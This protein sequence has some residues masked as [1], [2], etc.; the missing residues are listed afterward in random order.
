[1]LRTTLLRHTLLSHLAMKGAPL[2]TIQELAGHHVLSMTAAR[3]LH[4]SPSAKTDAMRM[5]DGTLEK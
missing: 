4:L 5:L 3:Y 1:M 2:R